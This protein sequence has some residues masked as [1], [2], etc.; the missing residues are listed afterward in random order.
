MPLLSRIVRKLRLLESFQMSQ[1]LLASLARGID[2]IAT[3]YKYNIILANSHQN[4][5][6]EIQVLNT[7]LSNK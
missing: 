2:D 3:M 7:L 6:I 5:H 1:T 4:N